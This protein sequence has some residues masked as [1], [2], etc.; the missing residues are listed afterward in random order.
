VK[1]RS[2]YADLELGEK[3][4]NG[5]KGEKMDRVS[6]VSKVSR[7]NRVRRVPARVADAYAFAVNQAIEALSE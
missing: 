2:P 4:G 1:R 6:K 3:G 5:L 7:V